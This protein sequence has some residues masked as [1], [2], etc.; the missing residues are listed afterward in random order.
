M[1][2]RSQRMVAQPEYSLNRAYYKSMRYTDSDLEKPMIGIAE[3]YLYR[4]AKLAE[5]ADKGAII[6]NRMEVPSTPQ[7]GTTR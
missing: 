5:S 4:Y 6:K 2:L 7:S 3:G 1:T